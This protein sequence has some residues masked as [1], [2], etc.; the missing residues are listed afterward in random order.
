MPP[1]VR[2]LL[3]VLAGI[4]AAFVVIMLMEQLSTMVYPPPP[5][6]DFKDP[7]Q[8]KAFMATMPTTALLLV[9]LGYAL[10][11]LAGGAVAAKL[12]PDLPIRSA[13]TIAVVLVI[14]SLMNLRAIPSPLWFEAANLVVV[15]LTPFAG[16]RLV[17]KTPA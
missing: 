9:L 12:S 6:I 5:G 4:V 14:G 8:L 10:G 15:A 7:A 1:I 3:A 11:G 13:G 16:E 2:R 17:R